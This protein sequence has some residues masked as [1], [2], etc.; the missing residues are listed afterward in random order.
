MLALGLK[1]AKTQ[2]RVYG[3]L[4]LLVD[5]GHFDVLDSLANDVTGY[6]AAHNGCSI[7]SA[8]K[9]RI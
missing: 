2:A 5:K 9:Q 6:F 7:E 4:Q 8:P 1:P 3:D